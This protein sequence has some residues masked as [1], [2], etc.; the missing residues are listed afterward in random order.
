MPTLV[1]DGDCSFCRMWVGYWRLLTGDRVEYV[2]YQSVAASRFPD[3]PLEDFR[4]SVQFFSDNG[5]SSGAEAVFNLLAKGAKARWPLWVYRHVPGVAPLTEAAYRLI[6]ANRNAGYKI[7]RALW[8]KTVE[9]PS[10]STASGIF[11]RVIALVYLIALASFGRQVRGLIGEQG[12]QPVTEFFSEVTRQFGSGGFWQVPSLFWWVRGDF[13]L[14]SIVWG[15]AVIAAVSAVAR[16]HTSGQKAAFVL[17]FIYYLSIVNA[18]QI[19]MGFQWDYLLLEAGFLAIFLKPTWSRTFLFRWLLFRLMFESGIVKLTSHDPTWRSLT[20]L[21]YHYQT[22]PLPTPLAW[23]M[24]QAPLWFLKAST[25]S[26][27]IVELVL[28]WFIFGPRRLKHVAAW[29]TIALQT[30]ILLTGNYTFFNVL[31]IGLCVF[32]FDDASFRRKPSLRR[33]VHTNRWVSVVLTTLILI[34][35]LTGLGGMF[36]FNA[37]RFLYSAI[38]PFGPYGNC[39]PVW[40]VREHDYDAP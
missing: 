20:A 26:V 7:T 6:A 28:P 16:P 23:Y 34:L 17:L 11:A 35:S 40:P 33:P 25:F 38:A 13:G 8:G 1:F 22:Q 24:H 29:G 18:G 32:L 31:T 4:R 30:M 14:E 2:P 12:I 37:P 10:Y 15:G 5:H 27:F 21:Q 3:V 9:P 39:E 36:G 19:F